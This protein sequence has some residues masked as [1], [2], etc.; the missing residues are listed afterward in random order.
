[1]LPPLRPMPRTPVCHW[2]MPV[3]NVARA[4]MHEGTAV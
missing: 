4:G 3:I 1:M 2:S